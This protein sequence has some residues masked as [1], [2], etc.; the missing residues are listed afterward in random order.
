M[1]AK[2]AFTCKCPI[3]ITNKLTLQ[4]REHQN[5]GQ[6]ALKQT[7]LFDVLVSGHLASSSDIQQV[8]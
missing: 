3:K 4:E 2:N 1:C 5:W 8:R 7:V 6:V